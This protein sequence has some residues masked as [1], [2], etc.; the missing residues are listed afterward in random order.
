MNRFIGSWE[1]AMTRIVDITD[2]DMVVAVGDV[3]CE[4]PSELIALCG[5]PARTP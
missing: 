3:G 4:V 5:P 2:R 1:R